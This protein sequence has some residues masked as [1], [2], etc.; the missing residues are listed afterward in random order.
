[1]DDRDTGVTG[2]LYQ[3]GPIPTLFL[4]DA[5]GKITYR[6]VGYEE[7]DEKE[8]RGEIEKALGAPRA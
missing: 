3:V 2:P 1:M 8:L 4:I 6:H 7:G 5:G